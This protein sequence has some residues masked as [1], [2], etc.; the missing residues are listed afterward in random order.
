MDY[1]TERISNFESHK[2]FLNTVVESNTINV[3][4]TNAIRAFI[5]QGKPLTFNFLSFIIYV[6]FTKKGRIAYDYNM[7][8]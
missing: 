1:S 2:R 6:L 3:N 5:D 8:K 4:A 7:Y